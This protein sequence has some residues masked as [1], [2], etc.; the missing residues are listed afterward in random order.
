MT[1]L[2]LFQ[3]AASSGITDALLYGTEAVCVG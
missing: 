1:I 2:Q 3:D